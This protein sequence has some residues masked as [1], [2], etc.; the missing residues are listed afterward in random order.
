MRTSPISIPAL[1]DNSTSLEPNSSQELEKASE[2]PSAQ[3][4]TSSAAAAP[5]RYNDTSVIAFD[6]QQSQFVHHYFLFKVGVLILG[7]LHLIIGLLGGLVMTI[8]TVVLKPE[9]LD[10]ADFVK[11]SDDKVHS[12]I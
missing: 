8:V 5:S 10:D 11:I 3:S 1:V 4:S 9:L 6:T 12:H 7:W 2:W